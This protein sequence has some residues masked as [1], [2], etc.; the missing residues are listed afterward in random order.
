MK[1]FSMAAI[2]VIGSAGLAA[3]DDSG[4]TRGGSQGSATP[5]K[6]N[7]SFDSVD[8]NGDGSLSRTEASSIFDSAGFSRADKNRNGVIDRNEYGPLTKRGAQDPASRSG[9]EP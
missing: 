3:A 6:G 9:S 5:S 7:G 2:L 4:S 1:L 8:T